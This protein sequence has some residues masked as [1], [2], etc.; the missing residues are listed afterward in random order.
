M[1]EP[2]FLFFILLNTNDSCN[3]INEIINFFQTICKD[4]WKTRLKLNN[5]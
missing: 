3:T 2:S 5:S 4:E 1:R